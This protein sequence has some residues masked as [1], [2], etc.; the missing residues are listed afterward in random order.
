MK[1]TILAVL[2]VAALATLSGCAAL[3]QAAQNLGTGGSDAFS[4]IFGKTRVTISAEPVQTV[5]S[6]V[7][8]ATAF[9][10]PQTASFIVQQPQTG[11]V[12]MPPPA[13]QFI[14]RKSK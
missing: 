9:A 1:R 10:A 5:V 7:P 13:P 8:Q 4:T 11:A 12:F 3:P 14:E 6:T 2:A